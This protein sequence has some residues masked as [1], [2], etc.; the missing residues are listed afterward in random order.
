[1]FSDNQFAA[2][3]TLPKLIAFEFLRFASA[4]RKVP[5]DPRAKEICPQRM[6][7]TVLAERQAEIRLCGFETQTSAQ[8]AAYVRAD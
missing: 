6:E 7:E 1:M 5:L 2:V 3:I 4:L 8:Q